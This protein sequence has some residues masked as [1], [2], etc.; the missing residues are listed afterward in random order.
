M[1]LKFKQFFSVLAVLAVMLAGFNLSLAGGFKVQINQAQAINAW[2]DWFDRTVGQKGFND[3]GFGRNDPRVII[4]NVVNILFGLLGVAAIVLIMYGGFVWMT[5]AG[6][7]DKVEQAKAILRNAFIGLLIVLSAFAIAIYILSRLM[8]A[9]SGERSGLPGGNKG[10]GALGALGAGIVKSVY[11]APEAREVPRNT[12]IIISFREA[13]DPASLCDQVAAGLCAAGAKLNAA[14]VR[15]YKTDQGDQTDTNVTAVQVAS[16]DN[17]TFIFSPESYL[18]SPSEKIWYSVALTESVKRANGQAAFSLGGFQWKFE[19]SN[20][21]DLTPPQVVSGGIFPSPDNAKDTVGSVTEAVQAKG[22]IEVKRVLQVAVANSV[23]YSKTNPASVEINVA[24]PAANTCDGQ[25]DIAINNTTPLSANVAYLNLPGKVNVPQAAILNREI[26]TACGFKVTLD[27]GFAPGHSW[28]LT[29]VS[30][31]Q[32]DYLLVGGSR[33]LFVA[34]A[35][36]SGEVLIDNNLNNLANNLKNALAGNP[37]VL[38]EALGNKVILTARTAGSAGNSIALFS[39]ADYA[40]LG[41]DQ[42]K[43]GSDR[44]VSVNVADKPD[45]PKNTI[46]Q[47]N[48]NEAINPLTVSGPSTA[49]ADFIK[50][51]NLADQSTVAGDFV[52]SNQ[53]Q[54]VEFVPSTECGVNGCGEKVYCLPPNSQLRVE[55]TA[56]ALAAVCTSDNDCLTKT[57]YNTCTGGVCTDSKTNTKYPAGRPQSGIMDLASNSLDGNRDGNA[58][59]PVSFFDE[60]LKNIA[61]GDSYRWSFWISDRLDLEPPQIIQTKAAM[62]EEN[63]DLIAPVQITFNKLMMA[64]TIASGDAVVDNGQKKVTHKLI[65]LWSQS[66]EPIGYWLEKTNKDTSNP[67]DNE[68]DQTVALIHHSQFYISTI[69]RS[70]V[71]SGLK[72]IYQNCFKPCSGPDCTANQTNASCCNGLPMSIGDNGSCP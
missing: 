50:V 65:N 31:K 47:I 41:L 34:G 38:A 54:T 15:I 67:P 36:K 30:Q 32:P 61:E 44:A 69:Y 63:V 6:N 25:I 60:N 8:F 17:R 35:P 48:F 39:S 23:A 9:V 51:I 5:A 42:L 19:V 53:Y 3:I 1:S 58:R 55:L 40:I 72:D 59:G 62:G 10:A 57:P 13:I 28:R 22:S 46:I 20:I 7:A 18:G 33:Y 68:A 11:P 21:L 66:K 45:K 24:N 43:G 70:Q 26:I 37:A 2:G 71:G 52:V 64:A 27:P 12:V 49:V 14:N 56:A 29:M 4:A 16:S